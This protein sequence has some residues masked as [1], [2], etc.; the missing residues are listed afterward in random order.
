MSASKFASLSAPGP[1]LYAVGL[2]LGAAPLWAGRFLPL[3][4]LPQHLHL[5]SVLHRLGDPT[6]LY[7]ELFAARGELTPYLGYYHLVSL[8]HWLL[9]L[10]LANKVYL[11]AY[12]VGMP[13]GM[14]FLLRSLGRPAWPS[15]LALPFA[16]GDSF[17]WGFINYFSALPLTFMC[18][19]LFVRAIADPS[20][21]RLWAG[22]LAVA[23][24]AV[25]LFHVQAFAFLGVGLPFLLLTTRAKEDLQ[26]G[27]PGDGWL[28]RR[29]R[30]RLP[31][32]GGVVP[33]VALFAVWFGGR[34]GAPSEIAPG[35]PWKAWGPMFS[36]Q[37]LAW[38]GFEQNLR[39]LPA[40]LANMLRDG[41]DRYA[42]AAVAAV[43]GLAVGLAL[44]G[45]RAARAEAFEGP[46]ERFR[47]LGLGFIALALFFLLPFDIRGHVYY[48]N[49]RFAHLAA[50]L[51]L[52]AVPVVA[53]RHQAPLQWAAVA[54]ALVLAVPLVGGVRAFNEEAASLQEVAR[55]V[56]A[57]PRVMGLIYDSRSRVV[58]HPVFLHS[59]A[60]LAGQGGG[61]SN[62]SFALTPHSPLRYRDAPPPTFP[63]EWRP[64][65]FSWER[66]GYAYDHFLIRGPHPQQLF[67]DRLEGEFFIAA[68]Q[69]NLW[70]V[71]RRK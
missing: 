1:L 4:D 34:L 28:D 19:G 18:C 44:W 26:P 15:L 20:R 36:P 62:F 12:V 43:A 55:A 50:P 57:K 46:V 23:L 30:P 65:E 38:K 31:A 21:R 58:N 14:A 37:N 9:P 67:G 42:L 48:L 59:A 54:S 10:E 2:A 56:G 45:R 63:S 11:S 24:V 53:R 25:L 17:A 52:A 40:V 32:L 3:V 47:L 22:L 69:D 68:Q 51:L 71:R 60:Y 7:P 6:T 66:H 64:N 41:S 39:E 33:A 13:L 49:T 8:L 16:Y 70:L 29:L 61:A 27:R 5:I 35:E